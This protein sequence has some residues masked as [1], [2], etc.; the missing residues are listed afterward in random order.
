M[1]KR[2]QHWQLVGDERPSP[3][4]KTRVQDWCCLSGEER[5]L[6]ILYYPISNTTQKKLYSAALPVC[7]SIHPHFIAFIHTSAPLPFWSHHSVL[8][9]WTCAPCLLVDLLGRVL[10][11]HRCPLPP[12]VPPPPP[13]VPALSARQSADPA[14]P[15]LAV[16]QKCENKMALDLLTHWA[17]C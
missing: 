5:S 4:F 10:W 14:W 11:T 15:P 16:S 12:P 2:S 17:E 8:H 13:L 1:F 9:S 3:T 6:N 7:P